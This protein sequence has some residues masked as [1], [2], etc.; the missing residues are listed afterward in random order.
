MEVLNDKPAGSAGL[1]DQLVA[2]PP[3]LVGVRA[4]I[5]VPAVKVFDAGL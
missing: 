3:V 2:A 4:L 5:A 1:M